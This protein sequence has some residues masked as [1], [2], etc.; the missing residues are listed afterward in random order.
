M[1]KIIFD[2]HLV[3]KVYNKNAKLSNIN[4]YIYIQ[5]VFCHV[6]ILFH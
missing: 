3:T 5:K 1:L 2:N 4:I 6:H